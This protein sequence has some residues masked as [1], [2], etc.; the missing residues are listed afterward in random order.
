MIL[1]K[2]SSP[3]DLK[4]IDRRY[5]P[6]ICAQIRELIIDTVSKT[7]GHIAPSLG[8]V[9]LAVALHYIFDSPHDKIIWDVGHQSYAHK[10]LTDRRESFHTLRQENGISGFPNINESRHDTFGTGHASTSISAALGIAKALVRKGLNNRAIAV[11]GDGSM[12]GGLALEGLNQAGHKTGNLIVILN[13]NEMSISPNVG[14]VSKFLSLHIHGKTAGRFKKLLRKILL[15]IPV[16]G[17]GL[18]KLTEKAEGAAV[19]FFTPGFLFEAFGFDYIGPLDGHNVEELIRVFQQVKDTSFGSRP[20][21][22]H[23]LTKKGKGYGPAEVDPTMFHGVGP[24]D[25]ATGKSLGGGKLT[26]TKALSHAL[27]KLGTRQKSILAI[28]AAMATGTGLDAF[29]G[30]FPDRFFDV[31]IAEG[32]A[33][34]FAAG[35]A[36]AGFRPVVAIYSTFLQRA[37]DNIVH[38][39]C[40]QNLPVVFVIDRAGM[41]GDDGP[42]HH[43]TFDLTYLRAIPNMTVLAPRSAIQLEKMLNFAAAH[44]GPVAIRYPRGEVPD[45]IIESDVQYI[46]G[47]AEIVWQKGCPSVAI[48]AVGH[49]VA[50]AVEAAKRLQQQDIDVIVVDPCSIKPLDKDILRTLSSQCD[51]IVTVEENVLSGGFGASIGEWLSAN[52]M[53][54]VRM[55]SLGLPDEFIKQA[56]QKILRAQCGIDANGI[57]KAVQELAWETT[58]PVSINKEKFKRAE[59]VDIDEIVQ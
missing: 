4:M 57:V 6:E 37:Y 58:E 44:N 12:T 42:T 53:T 24:F 32:H 26:Y 34:T 43:G 50:E 51:C 22:I 18:D 9:E 29:A 47:R 31:G 11:I 39:V 28:T 46:P 10:I 54:T 5:L 30:K 55:R 1:D 52:N 13:D 59:K 16:W 20:K 17:K 45:E 8:A 48:L 21:L 14:A 35:L 56:P 33:V 25:R 49:L 41:V 40:L 19:G 15:S 27:V 23:V 2:I 3:E 38:D 36:T 7:G